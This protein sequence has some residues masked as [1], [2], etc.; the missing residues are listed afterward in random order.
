MFTQNVTLSMLVFLQRSTT[1]SRQTQKPE[2]DSLLLPSISICTHPQLKVIFLLDLSLKK[3][4][5]TVIIFGVGGGS[6]EGDNCV[7][8]FQGVL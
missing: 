7:I 3:W 8:P 6:W 2:G 1:T 4:L 5:F